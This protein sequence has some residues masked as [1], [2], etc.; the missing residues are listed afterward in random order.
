M[1]KY[2]IISTFL[3]FQLTKCGAKKGIRTLVVQS[4]GY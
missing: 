3:K 2:V 4:T 1:N